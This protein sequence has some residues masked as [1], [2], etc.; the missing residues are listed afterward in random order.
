M[1]SNDRNCVLASTLDDTVR[2][3]DKELG[4]VLNG[5]TGHQNHKYK[6]ESCLSNTDAIVWSGSEDGIV[7]GWDLV[8]GEVVEKLQ[9]HTR[10]VLTLSY[11]PTEQRL[12]TGSSDGTVKLWGEVNNG[13][14]V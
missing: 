2:L 3:L 1:F 8:E 13:E 9:G 6:V 7:Y 4:D 5:Y 14:A 10:S 11:H 12:L